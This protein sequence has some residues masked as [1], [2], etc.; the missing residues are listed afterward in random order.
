MEAG[1]LG[2]LGEHWRARVGI[3]ERR[4]NELGF[5]EYGG[6][7]GKGGGEHCYAFKDMTK[8]SEKLGRETCEG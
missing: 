5:K 1:I 7:G 3:E 2:G 6:R 4:G 8:Q